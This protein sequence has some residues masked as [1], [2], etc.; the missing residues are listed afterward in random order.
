MID[1]ARRDDRLGVGSAHPVDGCLDLMVRDLCAVTDDHRE[2]P[3]DREPSNS[4]GNVKATFLVGMN[5]A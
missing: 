2:T 4:V 5:M 3:V 1:F